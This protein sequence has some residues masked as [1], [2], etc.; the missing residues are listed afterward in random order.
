MPPKPQESFGSPQATGEDD[1]EGHGSS[2][3]QESYG[4]SSPQYG[5]SSPQ[6]GGSSPQATGEDD[7]EGH[8]MLPMDVGSARQLANARESDIRRHLERH[9]YENDAKRPHNKQTR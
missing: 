4:G 6:F 7:V 2:H 3:P 1:V 5:G 9:D 8:S